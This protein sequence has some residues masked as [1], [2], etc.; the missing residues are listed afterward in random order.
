MDRFL[1]RL[2][3]LGL[4]GAGVATVVA[5]HRHQSV[6]QLFADMT[7]PARAVWQLADG[8]LSSPALTLAPAT[9]PRNAPITVSGT[10]YGVRERIDVTLGVKILVSTTSDEHGGFT[11]TVQV[12]SDA[13]CPSQQ[14]DLIAAGKNTNRW[15][16][17]PYNL[18]R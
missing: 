6:G 15:V 4:V 8:A 18:S 3:I 16:D 11:A 1:V 2:I 12:P 10:G 7:S 14:C 9:G 17:A 13:F 5:H